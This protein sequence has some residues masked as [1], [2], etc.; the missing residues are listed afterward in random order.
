VAISKSRS[1]ARAVPVPSV[2]VWPRA[3]SR[4]VVALCAFTLLATAILL[5]TEPA[6]GRGLG[7]AIASSRRGQSYAESAMLA[8]DAQL[9]RIKAQARVSSRALRHAKR[10]VTRGHAAMGK[11]QTVIKKRRA[12]LAAAEAI[13]ADPPEDAQIWMLE[14]RVRGLR[15]D[16][17]SAERRKASIGQR[18]RANVRARKARQYRLSSL[19]RQRA[20]AVGR[21][22][23][24]EGTL[25]A[26]MSRMTALAPPGYQPTWP[27]HRRVC[28]A[29]M[30]GL[31]R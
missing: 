19:R 24:A 17:R 22:E 28:T 16:V 25:A 5:S 20:S 2:D 21:R 18:L 12:R 23:S 29:C 11:A 9:S 4:L 13:L 1:G 3:A 7:D 30:R 27:D 14:R 15:S 6:A 31:P 10:A 26:Y 8:A